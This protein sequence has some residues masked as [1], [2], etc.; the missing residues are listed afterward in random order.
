MYICPMYSK[1]LLKG[2]LKTIVLKLLSANGEMY[3]Y[4]ITQKVKVLTNE[5]IQLTEGALYP[6]LHKLEADGLVTTQVENINGRKR[7]YY[8]VTA[9]GNTE[10]TERSNEFT[11]FVQTMLILLNPQL[12]K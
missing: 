12:T 7:K 6:T 2:T 8:Q 9:A 11:E 1:E 3:G 10:A 5:K 4:E